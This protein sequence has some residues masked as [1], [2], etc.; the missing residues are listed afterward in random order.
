MVLRLK[1]QREQVW[2]ALPNGARLFCRPASMIVVF[3]ARAQAEADL[4]ALVQAGMVVTKAG[5]RVEGIAA[6]DDPI[7][8]EAAHRSLF[9]V[10]LAEQAATDWGGIADE[11]GAPLQFD[12]S[13]LALLMQQPGV[14][15]M[16]QA[17]YLGSVNEAT[18][19][20]NV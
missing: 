1:R 10:A 3:A 12:A 18:A 9:M 4:V 2:V 20:G 19:E 5:G 14:A 11:D 13:L 16:F 7:G 8:M 15:D 17:G 6:P